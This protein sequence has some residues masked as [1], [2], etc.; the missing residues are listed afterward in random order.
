M[1]IDN[2]DKIYK[3]YVINAFLS[4]YQKSYWRYDFDNQNTFYTINYMIKYYNVICK[5]K[6]V[7]QLIITLFK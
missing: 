7:N 3:K 6:K 2:L 5:G 1:Y 4:H